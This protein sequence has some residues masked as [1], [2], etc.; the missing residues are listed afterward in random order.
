MTM[1]DNKKPGMK[2]DDVKH[3]WDLLPLDAVESIVEVM[4]FGANKYAPNNWKYLDNAESR[5][6]AALLRHVAAIDKGEVKDPDSGLPHIAHAACNALFL[7][8]FHIQRPVAKEGKD[9]S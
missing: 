8:W 6:K 1:D 9:V 7:L 3:R 2:F 4:T 5:Y